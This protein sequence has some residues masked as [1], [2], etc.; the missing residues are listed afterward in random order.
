ME[1]IPCQIMLFLQIN[2]LKYGIHSGSLNDN[3]NYI[4][5]HQFEEEQKIP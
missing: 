3:K 5:V 2:K 4:V 1:K